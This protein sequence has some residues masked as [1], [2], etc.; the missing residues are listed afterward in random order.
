MASL[1]WPALILPRHLPWGEVVPVSFREPSCYW[2]N[3]KLFRFSTFKSEY[4]CLFRVKSHPQMP[5]RL[6]QVEQR[7]HRESIPPLFVKSKVIPMDI[8]H[9]MSPHCHRFL[10]LCCTSRRPSVSDRQVHT[11]CLTS[12]HWILHLVLAPRHFGF[13]TRLFVSAI[14]GF[15]EGFGVVRCFQWGEFPWGAFVGWHSSGDM[16]PRLFE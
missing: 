3:R 4:I 8:P 2:T 14:C 11:M 5:R 15:T 10:Q 16:D 7:N 9:I 1:H 12:P 13:R 6:P